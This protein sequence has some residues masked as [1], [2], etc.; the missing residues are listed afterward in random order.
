MGGPIG[1]ENTC[2]ISTVARPSQCSGGTHTLSL[3]PST[4]PYL[5]PCSSVVRCL[6]HE[7]KVIKMMSVKGGLQDLSQAMAIV[8]EKMGIMA[9]AQQVGGAESGQVGGARVRQIGRVRG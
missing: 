5:D 9:Q 7:S 1:S 8:A 2:F 6:E 4:P 3:A